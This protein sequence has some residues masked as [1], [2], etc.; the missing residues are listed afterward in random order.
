MDASLLEQFLG[1]VSTQFQ[2]PPLLEVES[3]DLVN[4]IPSR[5]EQIIKSF[6]GNL[7]FSSSCGRL[8]PVRSLRL[9]ISDLM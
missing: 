4:P 5:A 8:I 1:P 9:Q 2:L 7:D 3:E 6:A